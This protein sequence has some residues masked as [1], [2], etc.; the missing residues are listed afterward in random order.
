MKLDDTFYTEKDEDLCEALTV[1]N[2]TGCKYWISNG[3]LLALIRDGK[4]FS[5]DHDID[6]CLFESDFTKVMAEQIDTEMGQVGFKRSYSNAN[7]VQYTK[8]MGKKIDLN[9]VKKNLTQDGESGLIQTWI[10][11]HHGE[12][13]FKKC[14]VFLLT[15]IATTDAHQL[16]K[17]LLFILYYF[18]IFKIMIYENTENAIG[19]C[20]TLNYF[21]IRCP[22]PENVEL[23]LEEL[24]GQTWRI[25]EKRRYWFSFAKEKKFDHLSMIFK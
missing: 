8:P 14:I 10:F 17:L 23:A 9:L 12:N 15:K 25:P 6:I 19:N 3:T 20:M 18:G 4:P 7:S 11:L 21:G 24:Y 13:L 16:P 1:M 22:V 2:K 5:W